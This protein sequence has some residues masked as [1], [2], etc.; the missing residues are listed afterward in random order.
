[1]NST[2]KAQAQEQEQEIEVIEGEDPDNLDDESQ[3]DGRLSESRNDD[4]DVRRD[5]S[6]RATAPTAPKRG[7]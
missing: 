4:E 3:E 5:A 2:E 6:S 1:M 7:K